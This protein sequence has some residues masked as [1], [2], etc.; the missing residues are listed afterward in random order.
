MQ[1]Q[2]RVPEPPVPVSPTMNF[3]N[4]KASQTGMTMTAPS[5]KYWNAVSTQSK[6]YSKTAL[7]RRGMASSSSRGSKPAAFSAIPARRQHLRRKP[8]LRV[9]Q[10][11]TD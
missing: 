7:I 6:P 2:G 11:Q 10:P 4:R 8:G 1:D 9:P 5:R 3:K